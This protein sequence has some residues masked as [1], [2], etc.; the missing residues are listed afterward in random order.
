VSVC[1]CVCAVE[2]LLPARFLIIH[3]ENTLL[4]G[5]YGWP[6]V[7]ETAVS[8][9]FEAVQVKMEIGVEYPVIKSTVSSSS[10]SSS[11]SS[12]SSSSTAASRVAGSESKCT[13]TLGG[14]SLKLTQDII[15]S[16]NRSRADSPAPALFVEF[17]SP[18]EGVLHVDE[19]KFK[20][21]LA[22][23]SDNTSSPGNNIFDVYE[24]P[25]AEDGDELHYVS[26]LTSRFVALADAKSTTK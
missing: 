19:R 11:F 21:K 26:T 18:S 10:S 9:S 16:L 15:Q 25:L 20:L 5:L 8:Q 2:K 6:P 1:E 14:I 24:L 13:A 7:G 4:G 12:S 17:T 22:A 23:A 3:S